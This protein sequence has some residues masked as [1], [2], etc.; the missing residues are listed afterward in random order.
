MHAFGAHGVSRES[1][2]V[3]LS[4]GDVV[5]LK[6]VKHNTKEKVDGKI[7]TYT[8]QPERLEIALEKYAKLEA[9]GVLVFR[10]PK[11]PKTLDPKI[12]AL[13]AN[14]NVI[15]DFKTAIE[16]L[17]QI[18]LD[19]DTLTIAYCPLKNA[20][21]INITKLI[22]KIKIDDA[23]T[24]S[25]NEIEDLSLAKERI[26]EEK[27]KTKEM[28]DNLKKLE[29]DNSYLK[30]RLDDMEKLFL[31]SMKKWEDIDNVYH[32]KMDKLLSQQ[33]ETLEDDNEWE[34]DCEE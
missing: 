26:R 16:K 19:D 13:Q 4:N 15:T 21:N 5:T 25:D 20:I 6:F 8:Y 31:S 23:Q 32:E 11:H 12:L 10:V 14:G 1:F 29:D 3:H 27:H 17:I 9:P 28:R 30:K 18:I 34:T 24:R 7:G 22:N 2:D 33:Q